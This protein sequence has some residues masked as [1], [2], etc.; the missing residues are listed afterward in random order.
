[1][2]NVILKPGEVAVHAYDINGDGGDDRG[3]IGRWEMASG[4]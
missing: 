4:P 2:F 3:R 1:M